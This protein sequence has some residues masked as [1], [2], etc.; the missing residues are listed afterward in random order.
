VDP[1]WSPDGKKIA[2]VRYVEE[3]NSSSASA[4]SSA[5]AAPFTEVA[6]IFVMNADGSDQEKLLDNAAVEPAWSPDGKEIAFTTYHVG[7]IEYKGRTYPYCG[8][9]VMNADGSGASRKLSTGPGCPSS[10]AWSPNGKK[11][12]YTN[13]QGWDDYEGDKADIYVVN[14]PGEGGTTLLVD[15]EYS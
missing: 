11:I 2:F 15:P 9:S 7:G 6:Y 1:A 5:T 14:A 13:A 4:P 10:P 8:V 3:P 12:A